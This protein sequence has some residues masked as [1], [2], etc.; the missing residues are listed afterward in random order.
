MNNIDTRRVAI[1]L[2]V[3]FG[4]SWTIAL[5]I[6]LTGGIAGSQ[7]VAEGFPI[8]WAL[9]LL[10]LYML[11]PAIGN[12]VARLLT[13]E[14]TADLWLRPKFRK[15]WPYWL[16]TWLLT[17][18]MVIAGGVLYFLLFP[19]ALNTAALRGEGMP[20]LPDTPVAPQLFI[21]ANI[22]A[23]ILISPLLNA[24]PILGEEFGWRAYLQPKLLPLGER[25]MYLLVGLIWGVWHWPVIW[26]GYNYPGYAIWGSMAMVWFTFVLG[27]FLGWATLR[28]G[29][30]WPAVI[31]HG[32]L[33]GMANIWL[34]FLAA[35][36]NPLLGPAVVGVIGSIFFSVAALLIFWKA[37]G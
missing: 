3:A 25:R 21:L 30:V 19:E 11:G 1:Y 4:F 29:S 16:V 8:T 9:L 2:L 23:A 18:L 28:A 24:L 6:Y 36:T 31:G 5:L 17:P 37:R 32:A 33:N 13:R 7:P 14:G 15:G 34:L 26:M 20:G 35:E 27:I 12:V 10:T 22:L